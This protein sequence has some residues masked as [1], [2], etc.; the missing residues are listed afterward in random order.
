MYCINMRI[1]KKI[2]D[3]GKLGGDMAVKVQELAEFRDLLISIAAS[4]SKPHDE[5]K[6]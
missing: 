3:K 2:V 5:H 4:A 1:V 6:P